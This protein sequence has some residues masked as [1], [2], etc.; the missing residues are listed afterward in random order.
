MKMQFSDMVGRTITNIFKDDDTLV[1]TTIEG[2]KFKLCHHQDCCES[3]YIDDIEGDLD[4]LLGT[5]IRVA[6]EVSDSY[7][8]AVALITNL[9]PFSD[10]G[11]WT[12]YRIATEKG[13]V[14]VRWIGESNGYYSESVDFVHIPRS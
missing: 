3:V 9:P 13:F 12:F 6:E 7:A 11:T 14:V 4:D 2:D 1:F 10:S 5:P 8:Q